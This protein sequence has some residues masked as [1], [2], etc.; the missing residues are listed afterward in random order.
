MIPSQG[1]CESPDLGLYVQT[2]EREARSMQKT[3]IWDRKTVDL[4]YKGRWR[5]FGIHRM[6][7][8]DLPCSRVCL[9]EVTSAVPLWTSLDWS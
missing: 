5:H 2:L 6:H 4:V 3:M 9:Q 8:P 7:P 1:Y